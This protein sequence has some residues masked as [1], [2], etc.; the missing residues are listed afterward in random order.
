MYFSEKKFTFL[1]FIPI[2]VFLILVCRLFYLQIIRGD[3]YLSRSESNFIQE[4][5]ISHSRGLILDQTGAP[6]VDNR[7]SHDLYV[8]FSLLP[9]TYLT[10]KKMAPFLGYK[11]A[12]IMSAVNKTKSTKTA[13]VLTK[14]AYPSCRLFEEWL[15]TEHIPGVWVQDCSVHIDPALFPSRV[16]AL[17]ELTALLGLPSGEM[18]VYWEAAEKKAEGLGKYKPI[19]LVGDLDFD[20]YARLEATISL[21]ALPGLALFDS[22]KRRYVQGSLAAHALG[23]L[24]EISAEELIKKPEYRPGQRLG[25]RG[26]E[27]MYESVLR[28][29]D[30]FERMVVDAKGRR[31]SRNIEADWLGE[32]RIEPSIPGNNLIL[33]LDLELQKAAERAFSGKAG[34]VVALEVGTGFILA[35]ASFPT[36]DPNQIIAR[37]NQKVFQALTKDSLK[38]WLNKAIQEHYAPGSTFKAVTAIAGFEHGLLKS[39]DRRYCNG[40][41]HLGRASWRC[42][43]REGH[44]SINVV[45]ALKTSCD[46]FFYNLGYELGPDRLAE[47]A[48]LLGFGRKTGVELDMEIPGIIP[49]RAYYQKRLGYYS[50][51]LVV[52][53][54]IGQ[55]DVT[56]TPLQLAVAY[57]AIINGGT[58]YKPQLVREIRD[59]N[60]QLI[61][62]KHPIVVASLRESKKNLD[63]VQE[64]LSHVMEPGGTASS[65]LW[66]YDLPELSKWLRESGVHIGGKTGT[67]QVVRL[68]KAIKHLKP[69]QVSY[70]ERDHA[71]FVGFAPAD[72]PEI[73]VVTMTEHGG[74][75]GTASAP[76]VA[77]LVKVWFE[78]IRGRGRYA[79]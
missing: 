1:S 67:A 73:V 21:G 12:K 9:D 24:N 26:I 43:E 44:G 19:L 66:R 59:V 57:D 53:S 68:S 3:Y 41:F 20:S 13:F 30:G 50:P 55:G 61:E 45:D 48:K 2:I 76:V 70:L 63:L 52:N 6:L 42:F 18:K 25:R 40:L 39:S 7:P 79:Q 46:V 38:P 33:S 58:L 8:T 17:K 54:A 35:M 78:K 36:Y 75:G 62:K 23:Y 28:G 37:N 49:D 29:E 69:D 15:Y 64:G 27:L 77:E 74:F 60:D 71:W 56:V 47:T 65:L 31:F 16:L 5:L 51:G 22:V 10:F 11:K 34:S 72:K 14:L 32:D 4:R